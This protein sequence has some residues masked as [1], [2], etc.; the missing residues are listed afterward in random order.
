MEPIQGRWAR[1]SKS[2]LAFQ[3]RP[4]P[5]R[6][7]LLATV[8]YRAHK[9]WHRPS[10][11]RSQ[12]YASRVVSKGVKRSTGGDA[13]KSARGVLRH[14]L[15]AAARCAVSETWSVECVGAVPK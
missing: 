13:K 14:S 6:L 15:G 5:A 11:V 10:G 8:D 12:S 4:T 3:S 7:E 1:F 2:G 9:Q